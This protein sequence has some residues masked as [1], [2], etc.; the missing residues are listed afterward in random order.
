MGQQKVTASTDGSGVTV[1]AYCAVVVSGGSRRYTTLPSTIVTTTSVVGQAGWRPGKDVVGQDDDVGEHVAGEGAL[2][3]LVERGPGAVARVGLDGLAQRQ[4]LGGNPAALGQAVSRWSASPRRA[5][6]SCGSKVITGQSL[7][8][9][10][11]P[12]VLG[13]A[14]PQPSARGALLADVRAPHI[15]GRR[16]RRGM[17]AA[18]SRRSRRAGR[19]A[20]R[21]RID[22]LDVLDAMTAAALR[23]RVGLRRGLVGVERHPHGGI[24]DGVRHDLPAAAGRACRRP[25][26]AVPA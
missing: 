16:A 17:H 20:A 25:W 22:R 18:A 12:P 5:A 11:R 21:P 4:A 24:A 2:A 7:P 8:K 26:S 10:S 14:R 3:L 9:A 23:R 1:D 6:R 19:S 15:A 13:D